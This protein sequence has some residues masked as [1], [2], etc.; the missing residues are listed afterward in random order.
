MLFIE[1]VPDAEVSNSVQLDQLTPPSEETAY[2]FRFARRT[3]PDAP[4]R[5]FTPAVGYGIP[6]NGPWAADIYI[7]LAF[8]KGAVERTEKGEY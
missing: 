3:V 6:P 7:L 4:V 2:Q 1:R 5:M 8:V